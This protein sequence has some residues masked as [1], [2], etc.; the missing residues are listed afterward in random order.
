[1]AIIKGTTVLGI[2]DDQEHALKA[3]EELR[4]AGFPE[5][6][7]GLASRHW[8]AD[9]PELAQVEL[10]HTVGDG[11]ITGAAVGSGLGAVAGAVAA[12]VIPVA[13]PVLAGG[14]LV[15]ALGGA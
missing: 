3:I 10:Q 9:V 13:G 14:L 4:R 8:V 5:D 6:Q 11:A 1:M 15:G 2:F 7:L 12:S